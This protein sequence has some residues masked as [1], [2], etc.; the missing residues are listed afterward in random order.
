M[1][2]LAVFTGKELTEILRT[3]RLFVIPGIL[4]FTG[5]M[6]PVL[7]EI[8][9]G[10]VSSMM[11]D[12]TQGIVIEIPPAT[13]VD[14]YLQFNKNA[15]QIALIAVIIATA[16]AVATERRSGTAQLVL[17]K[18][19]SRGA[20]VVAKTLSNW[21]LLLAASVV[22]AG[23]CAAITTFMFDSTLL[24]RFAAA[25]GLWY[26][27]A[28]LMVAVSVFLS[29]VTN[30]QAGAA[31]AG[32]ALY[33][34]LTIASVWEVTRTYTPAGLLGAGTDILTGAPEVSVA[35][36]IATTIVAAFAFVVAAAWAFGR[37]EL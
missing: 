6:S 12:E 9:P 35:W 19:V 1:R 23:L 25:V 34:A 24:G 22:S 36:P 32:I 29:V 15:M 14:A 33:F 3:W 13:T 16:G 4:L 18:P 8:A 21:L 10:L 30:S 7:A 2:G 28:V 26:L 37:Q 31:G 27:L 11:P 17:A 20:M 5:L